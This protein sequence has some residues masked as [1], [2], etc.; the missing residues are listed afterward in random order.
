MKPKN[1]RANLRAKL[2]DWAKTLPEREATIA[3][4]EAI[5]TGGSIASM[6]L[7]EKVNDVDV[8]FRSPWAA[9]EIARHY[10]TI[11]NKTR[12]RSIWSQREGERVRILVGG[13][14]LA[15]EE[16]SEEEISLLP[17]T[18]EKSKEKYRVVFISSNAI[19]LSDDLQLVVRFTGPPE[20]IHKNYDYVH[21]TCSYDYANDSLVLPPAALVSLLNRELRYVGSRYPICSLIRMR[22]FLSRGWHISAGQILKMAFDISQLDLN[23]C[24]VLQEQ[25]VGVDA[26]YFVQLISLL[27]EKSRNSDAIDRTTLIELVDKVFE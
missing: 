9:E 22:K 13:E 20:E 27:R 17:T 19:S 26:S 16:E 1:I 15:I 7:G 18:E 8:Y 14:G 25:L 21:C 4:K 11:V 3:L 2:E 24:R 12:T 6:L 23:D 10:L 5:V